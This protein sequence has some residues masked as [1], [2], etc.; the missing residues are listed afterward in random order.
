MI[1]VMN[2]DC[3][4]ARVGFDPS[5]RG[6]SSSEEVGDCICNVRINLIFNIRNRHTPTM[7]GDGLQEPVHRMTWGADGIG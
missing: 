1:G 7:T 5:E 2:I 6:G 3:R 4:C